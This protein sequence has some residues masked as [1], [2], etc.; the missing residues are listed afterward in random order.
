MPVF[1]SHLGSYEDLRLGQRLREERQARKLTLGDVSKRTGFSIA[2]LSQIETGLV[3]L[4][5]ET[6]TQIACAFGVTPDVLLPQERSFPYQITRDTEVRSQSAR[7]PLVLSE[8]GELDRTHEFWPLADLFVG[9]HIEPLLARLANT[10]ES[11]LRYYYHDEI[12][13]VFVLK[14]EMEFRMRTPEGEAVERLHDGDCLIFRADMPHLLR[15]P[16][17]QLCDSLHVLAGPSRPFPTAWDWYSPHA[18]GFAIDGESE[19]RD[20]AGRRLHVLRE[21]RGWTLEETAEVAG[22]R[23]RQLQQIEGGKRP[24]PMDSLMALTKAFGEPLRGFFTHLQDKPPYYVVCRAA[25]IRADSHRRRRNGPSGNEVR[26]TNAY[27]SLVSEFHPRSVF[28][29]IVEVPANAGGSAPS[30]HHGEE[31]IFV[32]E[33]QLV[34]T[35]LAEDKKVEEVLRAGDSCF[36]DAS[37]PHAL[38]G[39]T[40]NPYS[41]TSA[42]VLVVFWCPLGENYLFAPEPF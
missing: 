2:R 37:V 12:E 18:R 22:L 20:T 36:L 9:R 30:E 11:R 17:P 33:G 25:D 7:R 3:V 10:P 40:R 24:I 19:R 21:S 35:T 26:A 27:Y 6:L 15:S 16:H 29:C 14:G 38:R 4:D 5:F 23:P 42:T 41:E 28:P 32:L 31:F 39:E 1:S 8:S 34:L 13:F